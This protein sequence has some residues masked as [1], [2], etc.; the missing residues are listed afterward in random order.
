MEE[1]GQLPYVTRVLWDD[2]DNDIVVWIVIA[3]A[4]YET[5]MRLCRDA[6]LTVLLVEQNARLALEAS[7]Q[8]Y[9]LENGR[10]VLDGT[11]AELSRNEDICEF[12]LGLGAKG[13]RRSMREVKHYKRRKRWLS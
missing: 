13:A 6:G 8:A 9:V 4:I 10:V 11:S 3:Q 1:L 7:R 12:Y 2:A 5:V